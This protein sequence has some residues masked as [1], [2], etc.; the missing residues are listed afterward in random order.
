MYKDILPLLPKN[1]ENTLDIVQDCLSD[2]Q[3]CAVLSSPDYHSANKIILDNLMERAIETGTHLNVFDQLEELAKSSDHQEQLLEI[4]KELRTGKFNGC[5]FYDCWYKIIKH[6]CM[7]VNHMAKK[8]I[9]L[10]SNKQVEG[11]L[12]IWSLKSSEI[13]LV[14]NVVRI[15]Y[16][17]QVQ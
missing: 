4:I 17:I 8:E 15:A 6:L 2:N 13:V 3:I 7:V 16:C 1:Y 14:E 9:T 10:F 11:K 12:G 5:M